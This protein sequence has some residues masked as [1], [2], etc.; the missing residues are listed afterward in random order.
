MRLA[1]NIIIAAE[2]NL[3]EDIK[4]IRQTAPG[5][6]LGIVIISPKK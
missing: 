2:V 5:T 3:V 1:R 6:F 4:T